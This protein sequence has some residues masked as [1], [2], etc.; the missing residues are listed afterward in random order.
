MTQKLLLCT[1]LDR[2]LLPNGKQPESP[3]ARELFTTLARH[4]DVWLVFVT[5]RHKELVQQAI[6]Q[7]TLPEPDLV[8]SD[9]G[10]CI[11][12]LR[13][14]HWQI[15][16]DWETEITPD[17]AGLTHTDLC[18]L[19]QDI[20]QLKLQEAEKQNA[21]K[22]SYYV[23]LYENETELIELMQQRLMDHNIN[24]SLVWSIDETANTGLLDVLPNNA[25]KYHA[26]QFLRNKLG[27]NLDNTL[28][29]G[30][31]G[32]DLQVLTSDIPAI[33][34]GNATDA[35][36]QS[37]LT[38]TQQSANQDTVYCAQGGFLGMNG[39]YSA[40]ILEGV[41]HFKPVLG[42]WLTDMA[43]QKNAG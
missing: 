34:V 24:A 33:L 16:Q 20:T 9:V 36:R 8:I 7:Y 27:M 30:D 38:G 15:W 43:R 37:V 31:S 11:Y 41:A 39:N 2:T 13:S 5:G 42:H 12:D 3:G 29:A 32:N 21:H 17:W 10:S 26:I 18:S 25:T 14:E 28:F 4:P 22:L 35:I 19:F 6:K 1:D 23:P 40:G